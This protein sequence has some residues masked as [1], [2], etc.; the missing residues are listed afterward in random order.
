MKCRMRATTQ[1]ILP[2]FLLAV[3]SVGCATWTYTSPSEPSSPTVQS[4]PTPPLSVASEEPLPTPTATPAPPDL[5]RVVY[6][7]TEAVFPNPERGFYQHSESLASRPSR[8]K[9]SRLPLQAYRDHNISLVLCYYI[10]DS[11]ISQPISQNFLLSI[12]EDFDA[13]RRH[14]LKCVLRFAY[15]TT[16]SA[17]PPYGDAPLDQ[18]LAHLDQLA[19]LLQNNADVIA[20]MQ[21]GFIGIWGEWYYTDHFAANPH[22]P[23]QLLPQ[24]VAKRRQVVDKILGVLPKSRMV[25]LRTP[26]HKMRHFATTQPMSSDQAFDGSDMARTG[27]HN[28]CFLASEDDLGTYVEPVVEYPYLAQETTFLP[29]G[30]ETCRFNPPRSQCQTALEEMALFH[31]S[32]L[33]ASYIQEVL[34]DWRDEGCWDDMDRRLGYRLTLRQG[35]YA[36]FAQPGGS[37]AL[38]I[39]LTNE[40]FAAPFNP[41]GLELI[42]RHTATGEVV[43]IPLPDDP[44]LWLPDVSNH[45]ISHSVDI[46]PDMATGSYE[47]LLHLPDPEPTLYGRP[48]YAIR[49]ANADTWEPATGYNRLLHTV[50]LLADAS[51]PDSGGGG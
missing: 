22:M 3:L 18:V 38:H 40:G 45:L 39:E 12:Q 27:H 8:Q 17:T 36:D 51:D 11:F 34:D 23:Y 10:L 20:V 24:D 7:P 9:V 29:M 6:A 46:P 15:T 28:D 47:L 13:V 31:W 49:L 21:A 32:Y 1:R 50:T 37:F 4:L 35:R 33:S 5:T 16:A 41:R 30:G 44:R 2:P 42:W 25:Q 26:R 14:G 19:P 48:E 43:A